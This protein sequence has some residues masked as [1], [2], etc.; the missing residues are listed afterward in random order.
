MSHYF[1]HVPGRIRIRSRQFRA[2][3]ALA[4]ELEGRL[5]QIEGVHE[6][7]VNERNGSI[8]IQYE[9]DG[10]TGS[11]IVAV[12]AAAGFVPNGQVAQMPAASGDGD[13][14]ATFSKAIVG[15]VAQQTVTRSLSTLAMMFR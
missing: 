1:H 3:L 13:L 6:V 15:A 7:R 9:A 14:V 10:E 2:N 4:R 12:L 5:T 8:T 11:A